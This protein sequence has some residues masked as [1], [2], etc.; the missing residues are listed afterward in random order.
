MREEIEKAN[1]I[2][3]SARDKKI[4][5]NKEYE[6]IIDLSYL[7][8][9]A[10]KNEE[11]EQAND[12]LDKLRAGYYDLEADKEECKELKLSDDNIQYCFF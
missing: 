4:K 7:V 2:I 11:T 3:K 9:I 5:T 6:A 8:V 10:S 1:K 12:I